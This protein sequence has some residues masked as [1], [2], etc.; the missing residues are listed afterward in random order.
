ML[1]EGACVCLSPIDRK[2]KAS[3]GSLLFVY[4]LVE[5]EKEKGREIATR[6]RK[7]AMEIPRVGCCCSRWFLLFRI[8]F[9]LLCKRVGMA[10][11]VEIL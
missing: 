10:D 11:R 7:G 1:W 4:V 2:T 5:T 8:P 9:Y 6:T 3:R